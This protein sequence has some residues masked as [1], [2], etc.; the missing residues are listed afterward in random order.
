MLRRSVTS[1]WLKETGAGYDIASFD[2]MGAEKYIEVKTT[3]GPGESDFFVTAAEVVFSERNSERYR[4][5]RVFNYNETTDTGECYVLE[6]A[7]TKG[8]TLV[9]MQFRARR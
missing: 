3:T 1:P 5:Y 7:L 8:F 6:G 2:K 4:L 9:P